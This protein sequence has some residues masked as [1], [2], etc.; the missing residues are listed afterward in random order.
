MGVWTLAM[1]CHVV[2][3]PAVTLLWHTQWA[4]LFGTLGSTPSLLAEVDRDGRA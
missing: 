1:D 3:S 2:V 4:S